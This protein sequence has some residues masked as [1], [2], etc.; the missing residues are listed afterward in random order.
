[1]GDVAPKRINRK[2]EVFR[3]GALE[4]SQLEKAFANPLPISFYA[5]E[6]TVVAQDLLGTLLIRKTDNDL[7]AGWIVETEAYGPGDEANHAHRGMTPRN[8]LMFGRPGLLYVYR[9]YGIYWCANA[10]TVE[11]GVGEAVLLRALEPV[12]G[13][14]GMFERRKV[15]DERQWCRGPANMCNAFGFGGEFNGLDLVEG[16]LRICQVPKPQFEVVH[17]HR[18]GV[19]RS[20]HLPWRYYVK[21]SAYVSA[22]R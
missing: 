15:L 14:D 8:M 22:H 3:F 16:E 1:M 4:P 2:S 12:A 21:G 18:V 17:S 6:T 9:I 11:D 7:I 20:A 19:N 5:R 13:L 10:V